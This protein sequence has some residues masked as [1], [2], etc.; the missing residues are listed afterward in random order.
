MAPIILQ[1]LVTWESDHIQMLAVMKEL[2]QSTLI[3]YFKKGIPFLIPIL[4]LWVKYQNGNQLNWSLDLYFSFTDTEKYRVGKCPARAQ[5]KK[6][7]AIPLPQWPLF[8]AQKKAK[9]LQYPWTNLAWREIP[10]WT[11]VAIGITWA[12]KK[13]PQDP[14]TSSSPPALPFTICQNS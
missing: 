1:Y 14:S 12:K 4:I 11:Q 7:M 5:C 6:L 10:S 9:H 13:G 3:L 2:W 8:Y